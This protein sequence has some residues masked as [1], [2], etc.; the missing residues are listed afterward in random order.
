MA[1][2]PSAP[3]T[4]DQV[5]TPVGTPR[6]A[7]TA[8]DAL[9]SRA[10]NAANA[11]VKPARSKAATAYKW[12]WPALALLLLTAIGLWMYQAGHLK[13]IGLSPAG[14]VVSV[15]GAW[16]EVHFTSPDW[17]N[18]APHT[19]GLDSLVAADIAQAKRRVDIATFEY[20]L[21]SITAALIAAHN[22]GV[23]VRLVMDAGNLVDEEM[24]RL[25]DE[26]LLAG[27]PFSW[28]I[29]MPFMH[30][31]FVIIDE[32]IV[33]VGSWNLTDN[34]TY[35][36]NNNMIRFVLPQL[37]ANYTAEFEEMFLDSAFGP[38]SPANTRYPELQ[39][40]D[41]TTIKTYYSPEDNPR[42]GIIAQLRAAESE[43]LF[44]AFSFT[45]DDIA[46]VLLEQARAGVT[47]RGVFETRSGDSEHSEYSV[48]KA[49]G[50]DVRLDGNPRTMHHKVFVIDGQ[51]TIM[52]SYNF[53]ANAAKDNDENVLII[54]NPD[55]ARSYAAEFERVHAAA[56]E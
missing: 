45:D 27:I 17:T 2:S 41:G 43:I 33:W 30:D 3:G 7:E 36:N 31:K 40:S 56:E 15:S 12:T 13:A 9:P 34:D 10:A 26:L 23:Q 46:R 54:T 44:L 51:V 48:L 25:T 8:V 22:R 4:T 32:T 47:V 19:G 29:R 28:D 11:A 37:A 38:Q 18:A 21:P 16:Y 5:N 35:R 6:P 14:R 52:G 39:L 53:S 20:D 1:E 50:L 42:A 55:I 24:D 49:A